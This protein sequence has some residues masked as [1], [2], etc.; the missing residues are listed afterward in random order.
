MLLESD[1]KLSYTSTGSSILQRE[2]LMNS[3]A[4]PSRS[5]FLSMLFLSSQ[6]SFLTGKRF[7]PRNYF[8]PT[9]F[10]FILLYIIAFYVQ[11]LTGETKQLLSSVLYSKR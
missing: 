8:L 4:L 2:F 7:L 3:L 5:S 9:P 6:K 1:F 10:L 11:H